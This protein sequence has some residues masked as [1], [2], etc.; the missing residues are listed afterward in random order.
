MLQKEKDIKLF[1]NLLFAGLSLFVIGL[2]NFDQF[3]GLLFLY[4]T[5]TFT[6]VARN[7]SSSQ[8][9][10]P[11]TL[12]GVAL[13]SFKF[14]LSNTERIWILITITTIF[15]LF[16]RK[17]LTLDK[18][19]YTSTNLVLLLM[20]LSAKVFRTFDDWLIQFLGYGYDN[21][22]HLTMFRGYRLTS[23]FPDPGQ[24]GWFTDFN[25]FQISPA[26]S[27][28]LFSLFSNVLIGENHDPY[29]ESA[30]FLVIQASM[31][32]ALISISIKFLTDYF[33]K[34][35]DKCFFIT[36]SLVLTALIA[37]STGT[38]L[39]NGFPPYVTVTLVLA[40]WMSMQKDLQSTSTKLLNLT[41][42]AFVVLLITPGPFAFLI[43]PGVYL[44]IKLVTEFVKQKDYKVFFMGVAAPLILGGISFFEFTSTSG[45][46]GWRQ[47]LAPGGVHRPNLLIVVFI[48]TLF[49]ITSIKHSFDFSI[50]LLTFSG[51]LSVAFL[52][53]VTFIYTGSIQYYA[54][55][56]LYVWLPLA[57]LFIT[58]QTWK[59]EFA[60][61]NRIRKNS[62]GFIALFLVFYVFW[63]SS[64]SNGFMGT[65]ISAVRNLASH[66]TWYQSLVYGPNFLNDYQSLISSR[67]KCVIF[68]I[69]PSESDLNSRWANAL[70]NPIRMSS[71]C[72]GGYWNS[73]PLT[74]AEVIDRL[75]GLDE[76][77]LLVLPISERAS[78]NELSIPTNIEIKYQG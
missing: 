38:M 21:A 61:K 72:F 44:T 43:V 76:N 23:W 22:F 53:F 73:S 33:P 41:F 65:P 77:F 14:E 42:A 9:F 8:Y 4:L 64:P 18:L 70:T 30:A 48:L 25:L 71:E 55:K 78:Q 57:F 52:S 15:F 12:A 40:Y 7:T 2:S 10:N 32:V 6:Q 47:I 35:S 45:S 51:A 69:N 24:T 74:A 49:I 68:R 16:Y 27:S 54:V 60:S 17:Q 34:K 36:I 31:L 58:S 19:N 62:A 59:F 20:I 29:V 26:G 3:A 56:Q 28:A 66:S 46:F 39:V 5:I 50:W 75:R 11:I 37:Y 63:S 67:P 13:L 1:A